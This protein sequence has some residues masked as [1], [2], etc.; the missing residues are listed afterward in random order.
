MSTNEVR[1]NDATVARVDMKFE[2]V[3]IPVSDVDRAKEFYGRL[4]WRLD[5]DFDLGGGS[6]VVQLT[7]THSQCSIAFGTD[8]VTSIAR[9]P[10]SAMASTT[11]RSLPASRIRMTATIPSCW[12]VRRVASRRPSPLPRTSSTPCGAMYARDLRGARACAPR[13]PSPRGSTACTPEARTPGGS[14]R[15]AA[16][17]RRP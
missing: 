6:R 17:H 2:V 13:R 12:I 16:P 4:G 10:P 5:A 9:T 8:I 7:P 14:R 15:G 11:S 3:V 1:S